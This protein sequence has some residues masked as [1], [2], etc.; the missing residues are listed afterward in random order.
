[1]RVNCVMAI[2][3]TQLRRRGAR[4]PGRQDRLR[5]HAGRQAQR[6]LQAK[7]PRGASVMVVPSLQI[8]YY[9]CIDQTRIVHDYFVFADQEETLQ[10]ASIVLMFFCYSDRLFS[11]I[12]QKRSDPTKV[13]RS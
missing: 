1:M 5:Q 12:N 2:V 11:E 7:A 3:Q 4:V 8:S 13:H 6:L 9:Y 10:P